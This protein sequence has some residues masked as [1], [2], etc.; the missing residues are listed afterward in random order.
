MKKLFLS[1]IFA[2]LA[3]CSEGNATPSEDQELVVSEAAK[4]DCLGFGLNSMRMN[5]EK[6]FMAQPTIDQTNKQ[7]KKLLTSLQVKM[8]KADADWSKGSIDDSDPKYVDALNSAQKTWEEHVTKTCLFDSFTARG[9][10]DQ[11]HEHWKCS[12]KQLE[13]RVLQL[14]EWDNAF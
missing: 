5:C 8:R 6:E 3:S 4:D 1:V 10:T 12:Q 9:G 2:F 11:S 7:M 13:A 14:E